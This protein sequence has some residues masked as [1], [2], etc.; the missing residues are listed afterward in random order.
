MSLIGLVAIV[1]LIDGCDP[2]GN[3]A[4]ARELRIRELVPIGMDIEK[5]IEI[6]RADGIVVTDKYDPA[7]EEDCWYVIISI[8]R[9][10]NFLDKVKW[11]TGKGKMNKHYVLIRANCD[12]VITSIE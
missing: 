10:I 1:F 8:R 11:T 5:A 7:E 4:Q 12:G 9:K 3:V 6:L 2:E